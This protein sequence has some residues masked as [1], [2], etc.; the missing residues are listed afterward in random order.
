VKTRRVKWFAALAVGAMLVAACGGS[1]NGGGSTDTGSPSETMAPSP[2]AT[3]T[4]TSTGGGAMEVPDNPDNGLPAGQIKLGWMGDETGPTASAQGFNLKGSQAA[5]KYINDNGGILGREL[6][7]VDKDDQFNAETAATNYASLVN[8]EKILAMIQLGGSHISTALMPNVESDKLPVIGPP[9]TIDVQLDNP[10]VFNNIAHYG[11]EA[12]VA[13]AYMGKKLGSV[14][15]AKVAVIQLELPSGDEW[16]T[17]IKTTLDEQGGTYVDRILL[18][19]GSPDY[20]GTVTKLKQMIDQQGV[21]FV[22]FHGAPAHGLGL[23]QEMSTQGVDVPV[24]GIHGIAGSTIYTEG[25]EPFAADHFAGVHSFLPGT[26]DCEW[27][28]TI[29]D[30]TAGTEWEGDIGEINFSHGWLD[31]MIAKQ[32]IERAATDAGEVSRETL[33]QA[34]QGPFEVGG[35]TCPID[36]TDSNHSPC[37][38]PF[39]WNLDEGRI[40]AV[41]GITGWSQY[42]DQKYGLFGG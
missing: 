37:A 2:S 11:D 29:R 13:V 1:D 14:T 9:Q 38:A 25:P 24:V 41:D 7:L 17:Y 34:L 28:S 22:A 21:N 8:D 26:S 5:V 23:A 32:A 30:F 16:N 31:I 15:D 35:L 33:F 10:Y 4:G 18:N 39:E 6:V 3:D 27:C 40:F 12:D 19:A 36:W 20:P 42:L